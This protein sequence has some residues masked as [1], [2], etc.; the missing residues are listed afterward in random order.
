MRLQLEPA[1]R[2]SGLLVQLQK[3]LPRLEMLNFG[4]GNRIRTFLRC[5]GLSVSTHG[6]SHEIR[7]FD[8]T[9]SSCFWHGTIPVS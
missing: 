6:V 2:T 5:P 7:S 1:P 8:C 4:F 9:L 3:L